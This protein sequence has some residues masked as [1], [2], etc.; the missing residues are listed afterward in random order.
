MSYSMSIRCCNCR[1]TCV[2]KE[3]RETLLAMHF[4]A[5]KHVR[6]WQHSHSMKTVREI[7]E[8]YCCMFFIMFSLLACTG[9]S[10]QGTWEN[11]IW[12]T[13]ATFNTVLANQS[14][15][16]QP[17]LAN[18]THTSHVIIEDNTEVLW[19]CRVSRPFF[20]EWLW[21]Q[22]LKLLKLC[23]WFACHQR[24]IFL[25]NKYLGNQLFK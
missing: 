6:G 7:M 2:T 15:R 1:H 19:L 23:V 22:F 25:E 24:N 14:N 8:R 3:A 13:P 21:W 20:I 10:I 9:S 16:V 18:S 17:L 11:Q 4:C 12:T 5:V